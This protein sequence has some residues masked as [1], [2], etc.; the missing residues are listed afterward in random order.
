MISARYFDSIIG[1]HA[2]RDIDTDQHLT[3]DDIKDFVK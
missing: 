1:K 2:T 3:P